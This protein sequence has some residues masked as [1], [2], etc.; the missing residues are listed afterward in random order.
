MVRRMGLRVCVLGSSSAGNSVYVGSGSTHVLVDAGFSARETERRLKSIGVA[1]ES[2]GGICVSHEH[3]DHTAGL[4]VLHRRRGVP[5]YAN[6]ATA[7]ALSRS[8]TCVDLPW[9]IFTTGAAFEIGDLRIE[10]FSVPHDAYD[11]VG[12]VIAS[13]AVRVGIATDI[14]MATTLILER[15]RHCQA[16]V[17]ESNHDEFMLQSSPRPWSLKQRIASRHG[18]L[19]NRHAAEVIRGI[20]G[21]HLR[22][23]FLAHLSRECNEVD[24][25]LRAALEGLEA[26]NARHI[27]L[28][29]TY[30]DRVSEVWAG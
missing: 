13:G 28:A 19:S 10:P 15:L 22:H 26:V 2:I 7:E 1:A 21:P 6:A 5:V 30:P 20:C 17:L 8:P 24:L 25:A 3:A 12:F 4:A 16:V 11:P 14:G 18:H 29:P 23:V 27:H 9:R